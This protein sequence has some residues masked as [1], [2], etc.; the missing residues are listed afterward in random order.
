MELYFTT[1]FDGYIYRLKSLLIQTEEK[2]LYTKM[3]PASYMLG[4]EAAYGKVNTPNESYFGMSDRAGFFIYYNVNALSLGPASIFCGTVYK[5]NDRTVVVGDMQLHRVYKW[6]LGIGAALLLL[7]GLS[8]NV[9]FWV[10]LLFA[11]L[12]AG[13]F[14]LSAML[15]RRK[16]EKAIRQ[17]L[18][19]CGREIQEQDET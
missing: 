17:L 9:P 6:W 10:G 16:Q 2:D 13:G 4:K 14:Y 11:G 18:G 7:I 12:Y 1:P 5:E 15:L 3:N 19:R 8:R